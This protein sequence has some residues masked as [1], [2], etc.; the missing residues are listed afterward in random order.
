MP[1]LMI[2]L[3][4]N[5]SLPSASLDACP[6]EC[7]CTATDA[8]CCNN[9]CSHQARLYCHLSSKARPPT[10]PNY[11][12]SSS[13]WSIGLDAASQDSSKQVHETE[14]LQLLSCGA[15]AWNLDSDIHRHHQK[16]HTWGSCLVASS[17]HARHLVGLSRRKRD[18]YQ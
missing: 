12:S 7:A 1:I 6:K 4:I 15:S 3:K 13:A 9:P 16:P 11:A 10:R 5:L 18:Q 14:P 2:Y 8:T 17:R